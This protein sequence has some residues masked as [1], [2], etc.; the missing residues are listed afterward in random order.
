MMYHRNLDHSV[1]V[2]KVPQV[3]FAFWIIKICATALGE[4][5]AAVWAG[6]NA[7]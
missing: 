6:D 4:T 3:T 7:R 5:G 1:V 2:N